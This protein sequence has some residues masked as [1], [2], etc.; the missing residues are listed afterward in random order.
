MWLMQRLRRKVLNKLNNNNLKY[1]S[2]YSLSYAGLFYNNPNHSLDD[3][4]DRVA[5]KLVDIRKDTEQ[6]SVILQGHSM[7]GLI[8][9]RLAQL[10][11]EIKEL[12]GEEGRVITIEDARELRAGLKEVEVETVEEGSY[13][14]GVEVEEFVSKTVEKREV[15][16]IADPKIYDDFL[17]LAKMSDLSESKKTKVKNDLKEK[18]VK[19]N[20]S[21]DNIDQRIDDILDSGYQMNKTERAKNLADA[22][23]DQWFL[24]LLNKIDPDQGGMKVKYIITICTPYDGSKLAKAF[25]KA[26]K[27]LGF[28]PPKVH[29]LLEKRSK[30]TQ[31]IGTDARN[32]V[33]SGERRVFNVVCKTN[34]PCVSGGSG[35]ANYNN[36]ETLEENH[37]GHVGPLFDLEVVN[38]IGGWLDRIYREEEAEKM[39]KTDDNTDPT[40]KKKVEVEIE[41]KA[42]NGNGFASFLRNMLGDESSEAVYDR[43]SSS[44]KDF[45][46]FV[47]GFNPSDDGRNGMHTTG[48]E[49]TE[50]DLS[51]S[52][53]EYWA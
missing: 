21:I 4:V 26:E 53:D 23:A 7:G 27:F 12:K 25:T 41:E 52:E 40:T 42:E 31:L 33:E 43:K 35:R 18:L 45:S 11:D 39:A 29:E 14:E 49:Y 51:E 9:N 50:D 20:I 15:G 13:E 36:L 6:E 2:G 5:D 24:N 17:K 8:I 38:T 3:Y 10:Q 37:K 30:E 28:T 34:D 44:N 48:D 32:K 1:G 16:K 22:V 47:D 19:K 46:E